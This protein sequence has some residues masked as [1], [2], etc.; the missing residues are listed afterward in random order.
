MFTV[1]ERERERGKGTRG[2]GRDEVAARRSRDHTESRACSW[3]VG[4]PS[5]HFPLLLHFYSLSYP[6]S[7]L[8]LWP[9]TEISSGNEWKGKASSSQHPPYSFI[10][11]CD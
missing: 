6:P 7:F 9:G 5:F 11:K 8:L 2:S 4:G 3:L 10:R 1:G